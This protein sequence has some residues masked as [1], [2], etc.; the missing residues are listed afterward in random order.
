MGGARLCQAGAIRIHQRENRFILQA[1]QND[2][3]SHHMPGCR[4]Q[5]GPPKLRVTF[6]PLSE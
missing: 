1:E 2:Y 6:L 4:P 3:H 5:C